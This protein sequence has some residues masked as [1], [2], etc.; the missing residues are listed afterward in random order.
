MCRAVA[1]GSSNDKPLDGEVNGVNIE[2][3]TPPTQQRILTAASTLFTEEGFAA[4]SMRKLAERVGLSATAI[5]RH[6]ESKEALIAAVCEEG[7]RIFAQ[8]LWAALEEKQPL[9]RMHRTR[10]QYLRFALE[11][12]TYYRTMFMT[13]VEQLGWTEMPQQNQERS[14]STFLFLVDRVRECQE[15]RVLRAGQPEGLAL[16]LWAHGHGL[17]S[18]WLAGHLSAMS[19]QEFEELYIAS[20][21]AQLSGLAP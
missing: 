20:C 4:F 7:F 12:G 10:L 14:H 15:A 5:Y 11:H 2:L 6:F 13:S 9:A 19:V 18:L 8:F 17:A 21:A 16:Q 3:V 1:A